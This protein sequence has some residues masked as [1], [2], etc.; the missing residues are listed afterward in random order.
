MFNSCLEVSLNLRLNDGLNNLKGIDF[1]ACWEAKR[2]VILWVR[3]MNQEF[4][5]VVARL[6]HTKYLTDDFNTDVNFLIEMRN[7][8]IDYIKPRVAEISMS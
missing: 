8:V 1:A 4:L 5:V 2:G 7:V 3:N 6:R